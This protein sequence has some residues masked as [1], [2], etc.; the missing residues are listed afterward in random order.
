M[1]GDGVAQLRPHDRDGVLAYPPEASR[2]IRKDINMVV[3]RNRKVGLTTNVNQTGATLT[4]V[5][6][7]ISIT[8]V[9]TR[10]PN[11]RSR[12]ENWHTDCVRK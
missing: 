6:V 10:S 5:A 9:R 3:N 12:E 2:Q 4:S 8:G 1:S 7:V 11:L